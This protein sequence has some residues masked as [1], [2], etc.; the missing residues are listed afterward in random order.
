MDFFASSLFSTK[1]FPGGFFPYCFGSFLGTSFL[2]ALLG[3]EVP[4]YQESRASIP[5]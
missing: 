2:L 5:S 3:I 4:A 1:V